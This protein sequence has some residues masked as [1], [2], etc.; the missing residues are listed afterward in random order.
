M[1]K[2][3]CIHRTHVELFLRQTDSILNLFLSL[4]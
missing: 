3:G 2:I 1:A 4:D